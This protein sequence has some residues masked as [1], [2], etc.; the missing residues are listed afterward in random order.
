MQ[1]HFSY[2]AIF[3]TLLIAVGTIFNSCS[4]I[5]FSG[6]EFGATDPDIGQLGNDGNN[7]VGQ[8]C[9]DQCIGKECEPCYDDHCNEPKTPVPYT[10]QYT[11]PTATSKVDVWF[12]LDDSGSM[13][14]ELKKL[15]DR[16]EDF[17]D[18]LNQGNVDWQMCYTL[19]TVE[20]DKGKI[21][22]DA[23][24]IHEWFRKSDPNQMDGFTKDD[25]LSINSRVLTKN[26]VN[27]M[28][29]AKDI[30]SATL[31]T[32]GIFD[33][34]GK[35]T[36]EQAVASARYGLSQAVNEE[37]FRSD[38]ALA[39]IIVSDE[40][41]KS[42]G[43]RCKFGPDESSS[44]DIRDSSKYTNQYRALSSID[45]PQ[46]LTRAIQEKWPNQAKAFTSHSISI[47]RGDKTCY[48]QQDKDAP[49][50]YGYV[51]QELSDLTDGIKGDICAD[52]Y[53]GQLTSVAERTIKSLKS[54]TLKCA[55]S[56]V[57]S[58]VIGSDLN[59]TY[60]V[61]GD[62]IYFNPELTEGTQVTVNY[63]CLE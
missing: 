42:C 50:F 32:I 43:G 27:Q 18:V 47:L 10:S 33:F 28:A 7:C 29:D 31:D 36:N 2:I 52:D 38:A 37:C 21:R 53:A 30:F 34:D 11:V 46:E 19:T 35:S 9:P 12:V 59:I 1:R 16:L 55:P 15:S 5:N 41:E 60:T 54:L 23:G 17:V 20:G 48:D 24:A 39:M 61:S 8:D 49:A 44:D 62:K 51:Y 56:S 22:Q 57:E 45:N 40:D 4:E 25:F 3:A 63:T 13:K 14:E 26:T 6:A 58:V